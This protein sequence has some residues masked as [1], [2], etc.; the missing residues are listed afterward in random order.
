MKKKPPVI[1]DTITVEGLKRSQAEY[2][3]R[4][5]IKKS[6]YITLSTLKTE[7]FKLLADNKIKYIFPTLDYNNVTGFYRLNLKVQ[8]AEHFMTEFG[9]NISS[10][11]ANAAYLGVEY[12]WFQH[13]GFTVAADGYFGRFYSSANLEGRLDFPSRFP[14]YLTTDYTYN[15]KDYF[16]NTTYFFEDKTP[17]FLIQNETHFGVNAGIPATNKGKVSIGFYD[18][19]TKDEYYQT[20]QFSRSDTSD[21]TYFDFISPHFTF[22][23]NSLNYKQFANAGMRFLATVKWFNGRERTIPGSTSENTMEDIVSYHNWFQIKILYDDYFKTVGPLKLCFYG[24]LLL[25]NQELFS[26]YTATILRTPAF[27]PIPEMKTLFLPKY[28][29]STFGALGIKSILRIYKQVNL[30][31]EGYL[32]QPYQELEKGPDQEALRRKPFSDRSYVF[33]SSIVYH[34]IIGP[35]SLSFNYYDRAVNNTSFMFNIGYIIFNKSVFD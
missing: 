28:R 14:L 17:S 34:S 15:H 20:N 32:F 16:R 11:S 27:E 5:F 35:V 31:L 8:R 21:L 23:I 9:G 13:F 26:N 19:F 18:G 1:I 12:R 3:E 22:D 30:R 24:E 29:A 6:K 4:F 7:Y 25:S 10:S 33:S 2:I